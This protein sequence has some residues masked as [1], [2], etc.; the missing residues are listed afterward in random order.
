M[1][2]VYLSRTLRVQSSVAVMLRW[3]NCIDIDYPVHLVTIVEQPIASDYSA[4]SRAVAVTQ[5]SY[6]RT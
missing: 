5:D 6:K 3:G 2:S 1:F 4:T